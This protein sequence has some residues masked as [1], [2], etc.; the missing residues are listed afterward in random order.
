[1]APMVKFVDYSLEYFPNRYIDE[2]DF[3]RSHIFTVAHDTYLGDDYVSGKVGQTSIEFSEV[4]SAFNCGRG[5]TYVSFKGLFFLADFNKCFIGRTV[6]LPDKAEKRFGRLGR[7]FQKKQ[8]RWGQRVD[9]ENPAFERHFVVYSDD[10]V[11]A[12]YILSV[13]L[14]DRIVKFVELAKRKIYL[15][16]IDSK[17]YI[18]IPYRQNRFAPELFDNLLDFNLLK[19]YFEEIQLLVGVVD[20]LNLNTRIWTKE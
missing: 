11:I 9:L 7:K 8:R 1:M 10:Q 3:I 15:S 5:G 4:Y 16:F 14:M 19:G 6:V 13:N 18:A 17:V 2:R 20:D 12:R